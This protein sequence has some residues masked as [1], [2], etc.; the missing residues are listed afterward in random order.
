MESVNSLKWFKSQ[1][2][3]NGN[4]VEVSTTLLPTQDVVLLRD[5]KNPD[6]APFRFT[7]AEWKAFIG[8]ARDG[9]FD[10]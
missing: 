5:S 8:G 1:R 3:G 9:E 6:S 10:I 7:R 4:C 2:S